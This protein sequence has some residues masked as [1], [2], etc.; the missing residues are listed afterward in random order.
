MT[1]T[2][3]INH[4]HGDA[5]EHRI[6]VAITEDGAELYREMGYDRIA[7]REALRRLENGLDD[8]AEAYMPVSIDAGEDRL[9]FVGQVLADLREGRLS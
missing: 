2:Y 4:P 9:C 1:K 7:P 6:G 5:N 8:A 3:W